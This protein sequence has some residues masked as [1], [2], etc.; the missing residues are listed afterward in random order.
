MPQDT[1]VVRFFQSHRWLLR[2]PAFA[3]EAK[4]RLDFARRSLAAAQTKAERARIGLARRRAA[5]ARRKQQREQIRLLASLQSPEEAICHVFGSYCR[6]ALQVARCESGLRTSAQNGEYL[7]MFQ[8][9]TNERT[10]FGHG[11]SP[12]DQ[13]KA[14][15]RYFVRSGRDW[16]PWS[17]KPWT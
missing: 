3:S 16:S 8:M 6:Q 17:C 1:A 9:G 15:H 10:L 5:V 12:L 13:A 14:A 11:D 4:F 2:D 7:G